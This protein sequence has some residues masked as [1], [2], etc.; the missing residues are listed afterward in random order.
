MNIKTW[1]NMAIFQG[2]HLDC[3]PTL[4]FYGVG[5]AHPAHAVTAPMIGDV[6]FRKPRGGG[7]FCFFKSANLTTPAMTPKPW[8]RPTSR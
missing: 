6:E 4:A 7:N 1:K 3:V 5:N 2:G 8:V